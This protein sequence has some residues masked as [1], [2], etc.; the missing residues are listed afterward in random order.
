MNRD[1]YDKLVSR[2]RRIYKRYKNNEITYERAS[3]LYNLAEKNYV[4]NV[5]AAHNYDLKLSKLFFEAVE[6]GQ[7]SM[8]NEQRN[9]IYDMIEDARS[10][11]LDKS[12]S[13]SNKSVGD[14]PV[15]EPEDDDSSK[16]SS[17]D[18]VD[19]DTASE[20]AKAGDVEPNDKGNE[21]GTDDRSK[22]VHESFDH[23]IEKYLK[24]DFF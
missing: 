2:K 18:D 10:S 20:L 11:D 9:Y 23:F 1:E 21:N 12:S 7:L 24:D 5:R 6:S 3:F 22:P 13:N 4:E 19:E 17:A 14:P 8:T 15:P 16:S